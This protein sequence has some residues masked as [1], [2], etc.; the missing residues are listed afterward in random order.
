MKI[1]YIRKLTASYMVLAQ[2]EELQEW[3]KKMIA[4]APKGN[5][6]FAECVQENGEKYLWYNITGK[7]A[8]DAV[9]EQDAILEVNTGAGSRGH[10]TLPYPAPFLLRAIAQRGGR[11]TLTADSHSPETIVFGY[12]QALEILQACGFSSLWY[13]SPEGFREGPLPQL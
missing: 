12:R 8:L 3:E 11:I 7:Q 2:C 1:Q 5:I 4:H 13:L 10:R 6:V 9:L